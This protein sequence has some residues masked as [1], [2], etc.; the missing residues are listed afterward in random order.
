MTKLDFEEDETGIAFLSDLSGW[1]YF[2][3]YPN[4]ETRPLSMTGVWSPVRGD[5]GLASLGIRLDDLDRTVPTEFQRIEHVFEL[6]YSG[7]RSVRFRLP[8][9]AFA[10]DDKRAIVVEL[11]ATLMVQAIWILHRGGDPNWMQPALGALA[12]RWSLL[13]IDDRHDFQFPLRDAR[14]LETWLAAIGAG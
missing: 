11:S 8:A 9:T 3:G 13:L 5:E 1:E 6:S 12:E 10:L 2:P 14:L 7:S 4:A